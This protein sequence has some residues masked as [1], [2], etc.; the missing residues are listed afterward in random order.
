MV[1]EDQNA[2]KLD[3]QNL[4]ERLDRV[5]HPSNGLRLPILYWI[6][7]AL[8]LALESRWLGRMRIDLDV[9]AKSSAPNPGGLRPM[10]GTEM[11]EWRHHNGYTQDDLMLELGVKSRQTISNWEGSEKVPRV[12]ELALAALERDPNSRNIHGRERSIQR[13]L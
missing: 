4:D 8:R 11:K 12:V 9:A 1:H 7:V 6:K 10:T 13:R 2:K 3:V 5:G